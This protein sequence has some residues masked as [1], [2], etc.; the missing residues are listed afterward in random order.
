MGEGSSSRIGAWERRPAVFGSELGILKEF[1]YFVRYRKAWWL[2]PVVVAL[3]AIAVLVV[4]AEGS[5]LAPFI[6]PL[7]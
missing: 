4:M 5:A 6:Y 7:F 1:W 2:L 3:L